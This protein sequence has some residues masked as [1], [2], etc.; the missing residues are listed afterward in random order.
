M[1]LLEKRIKEKIKKKEIFG[2]Q[3]CELVYENIIFKGEKKTIH[4]LQFK[5][6]NIPLE[7]YKPHPKCFK[8]HLQDSSRF[9]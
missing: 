3:Y 9:R 4:Y 8:N 6:E 7:N 2:C 1:E 5:F